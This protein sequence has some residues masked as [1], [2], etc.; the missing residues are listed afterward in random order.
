MP[1]TINTIFDELARLTGYDEPQRHGPAKPGEVRTTYLHAGRAQRELGWSAQVSLSEGLEWTVDFF[2][3]GAQR[4]KQPPLPVFL[5]LPAL[6][7]AGTALVGVWAAYDR[8]Q[9]WVRYGLLAAGLVVM[10]G[11]AWAGRR[12]GERFLGP[13]AIGCAWLAAALG[14]YYLLGA[15]P[16]AG[17]AKFP[18]LLPVGQ[19]LQAHR[20]AATLPEDVHPNVA[21][22]T[23]VVLLPLGVGGCAWAWAARAPCPG[24][25]CTPGPPA[26]CGCAAVHRIARGLAG[27][28]RRDRDGSWI[29][30]AATRP[31]V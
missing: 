23:L 25:G 12:W 24:V 18:A 31:V 21:G 14:A 1:T 3:G 22:G 15:D 16:W 10:L 26:G 7:F 5:S 29:Q 11:I 9:A 30:S 2:R 20:P 28:G 13:A 4:V 8:G 27:T 6:A 17:A 19:W